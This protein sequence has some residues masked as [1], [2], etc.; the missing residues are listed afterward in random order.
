MGIF[1]K[2][3]SI[4]TRR[5]YPTPLFTPQN[6]M[7]QWMKNKWHGLKISFFVCG[8]YHENYLL[9]IQVMMKSFPCYLKVSV[10]ESTSMA[11]PLLIFTWMRPQVWV[12]VSILLGSLG[13]SLMGKGWKPLPGSSNSPSIEQMQHQQCPACTKFKFQKVW[14]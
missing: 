9:G 5:W 2:M 3:K 13:E 6:D 1:S 8:T 14:S 12:E 7:Q 4:D 11:S 10:T